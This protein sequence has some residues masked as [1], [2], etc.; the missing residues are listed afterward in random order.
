MLKRCRSQWTRVVAELW[1]TA[2]G[3]AILVRHPHPLPKE[4]MRQVD[5]L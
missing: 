1:L 3:F 4:A 5:G 2:G